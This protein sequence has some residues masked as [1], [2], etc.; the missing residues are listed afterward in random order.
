MKRIQ[1]PTVARSFTEHD[2]TEVGIRVIHPG[3]KTASIHTTA[4]HDFPED[5]EQAGKQWASRYREMMWPGAD[6]TVLACIECQAQPNEAKSGGVWVAVV[7]Y[8]S[9]GG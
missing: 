6:A 8:H 1:A 9:S 5:A 4:C 3:H 2:L 7:K